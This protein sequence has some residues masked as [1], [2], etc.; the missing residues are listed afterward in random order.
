MTPG[1]LSVSPSSADTSTVQIEFERAG[2][3]AGAVL[4]TTLNTDDFSSNEAQEWEAL[5]Q[6]A[7]LTP[8]SV[9]N[10]RPGP[11]DR[12]EYWF[13]ISNGPGTEET[14]IGESVLTEP[15]RALVRRLMERARQPPR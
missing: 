1:T 3:F 12:F 7:K 6:N 2:G 8:S 14:R 15:Q 9:P 13:R 4:S 11:P 5:V 10:D